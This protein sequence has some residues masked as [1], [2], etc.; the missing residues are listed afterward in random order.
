MKRPRF[1]ASPLHATLAA[2]SEL[3]GASGS[4]SS[5]KEN[6][7]AAPAPKPGP[8]LVSSNN[9]SLTGS[10]V[11]RQEDASLSQIL[12]LRQLLE[13]D[14]QHHERI[15]HDLDTNLHDSLV[16]FGTARPH[17][18]NNNNPPQG[19]PHHGHPPQPEI[20]MELSCSSNTSAVAAFREEQ[21]A[22]N[23]GGGGGGDIDLLASLSAED[24]AAMARLSTQGA[25]AF[26]SK[27]SGSRAPTI[28][29]DSAPRASPLSFAGSPE[30]IYDEVVQ[31]HHE[32]T[33]SGESNV[34]SNES[35]TP[36]QVIN[37][38]NIKASGPSQFFPQH[39]CKQSIYST[40][41]ERP[42]EEDSECARSSACFDL[43]R[44][45]EGGLLK[46]SDIESLLGKI[47]RLTFFDESPTRSR[48]E[49]ESD[50]PLHRRPTPT[51]LPHKAATATAKSSGSG[52]AGPHDSFH[53][54]HPRASS[55]HSMGL[56]ATA[57]NNNNNNNDPLRQS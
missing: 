14:Q 38:T 23:G 56:G 29:Y 32:S 44:S 42:N 52:A 33:G 26:S 27:L 50:D 12:G 25:T 10:F 11:T 16:M 15:F 30:L 47:E 40:I 51:H 57:T 9:S 17:Y 8:S 41:E 20:T 13:R 49:S 7:P 54:S 46:N 53:D 28:N 21:K 1:A 24:V 5:A 36:L 6:Y 55:L 34:N 3:P 39:R 43:L 22:S 19:Y 31:Q 48:C 18:H 2:L 35:S 4:S 37:S 45:A